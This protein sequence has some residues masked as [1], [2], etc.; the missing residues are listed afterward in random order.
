ML[1]CLLSTHNTIQTCCSAFW[2]MPARLNLRAPIYLIPLA[3]EPG[4]L[5]NEILPRT[6]PL[7][8]SLQPCTL[9]SESQQ[10]LVCSFY[11]TFLY[12]PQ[13]LQHRGH[14]PNLRTLAPG[15]HR[16]S[17]SSLKIHPWVTITRPN[18]EKEERLYRNTVWPVPVVRTLRCSDPS[19]GSRCTAEVS[20]G[21]VA[22]GLSQSQFWMPD[23]LS[24]PQ[25]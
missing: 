1:W 25:D 12:L 10:G 21:R 3:C 15:K 7:H 11:F 17:A 20:P 4:L 14:T 18:S 9:H 2:L 8:L 22:H 24:P 5:G 19:L 16:G 6:L 23:F 13:R